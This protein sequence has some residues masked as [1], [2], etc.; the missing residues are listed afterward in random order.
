MN[1]KL[2]LVLTFGALITL[3]LLLTVV[4]SFT[5]L[6]N[7][8][9][10]DFTRLTGFFIFNTVLLGILI[11]SIKNIADNISAP[12]TVLDAYF[13]HIAKPPNE[14]KLFEFH[15]A[16]LQCLEKL[17]FMVEDLFEYAKAQRVELRLTNR[18]TSPSFARSAENPES[19]VQSCAKQH[20]GDRWKCGNHS[21]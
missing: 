17:R 12:L 3:S 11:F 8:P 13:H 16:A 1:L 5:L 7:A 9:D 14:P 4:S 6:P 19:H 21:A 2:R 15:T 18:K 10:F 20:S